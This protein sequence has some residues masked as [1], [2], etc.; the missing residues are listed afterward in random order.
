[1][2]PAADPWFWAVALPAVLL[3]GL[4]KG[5]LGGAGATATPLL[6]LVLP[7]G[8]AAAIMLVVLCVL[9][10]FGIRAYLWRWDRHVLSVIVPAGLVGCAVGAV[11]FRYADENWIRIL[12]GVIVLGY[13]AWSLYPRKI[14]S[15]KPSDAAGWLWGA[16]SGF[17]SFIT[18]SGS[19]PLMVYLLPQRLEKDVFIA[20]CLVYFAAMNYA[21][22]LPYLWLGLLDLRSAG[23]ALALVPAGVAGI[24]LG[25]WLQRRVDVRWFYRMLYFLFFFTGAKLLYDGVAGL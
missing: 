4:S 6:A 19:P 15:G 8:Q 7:P 10:I 1:L 22:I 13:L 16:V 25:M 20:T 23:A 9:D 11:T 18:H 2:S 24:Y 5:G 3:S 12:I 21:K 17:A 14:A